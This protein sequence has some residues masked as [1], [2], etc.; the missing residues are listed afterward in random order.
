MFPLLHTPGCGEVADAPDSHDMRLRRVREM[1]Q[2]EIRPPEGLAVV[3]AAA[4]LIQ[5]LAHRVGAVP[6]GAILPV[7]IRR[8]RWS[9][10]TVPL[11][12]GAAGVEQSEAVLEW[13]TSIA[14]AI[15]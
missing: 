15:Q 8:Q 6:A 7:A 4:T 10:L 9:P 1:L 11:L 3:R 12:W 5:N 2:R 13:L 14:P